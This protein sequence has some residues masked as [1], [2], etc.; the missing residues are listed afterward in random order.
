MKFLC[1]LFPLFALF[2]ASYQE[3]DDQSEL[4]L[5]QPTFEEQQKAKI[6]LPNGLRAYLISDPKADQSGAA[7]AVNVGSWDDPIDRS[8]MAHFVEHMLFYGN[9]TYP[10]DH[11]MFRLTGD[12]NGKLNAFTSFDR[13]VYLFSVNHET[14][15]T[16]LD[17]LAHFVID[18]CFDD[19]KM[20]QELNA[21]DQEYQKNS[22]HDGWRQQFIMKETGNPEHPNAA[23]STGN[24][25]TLSTITAQE[26]EKW[27]NAHYSADK[28]TLVVYSNEPLDTLKEKVAAFFYAVPKK[29]DYKLA[30]YPPLSS[31]HQKGSLIAIEPVKDIKILS[32]VWELPKQFIEDKSKAADLVAYIL[33]RDHEKSL[34]R[35]LKQ[36]G[37]AEDLAVATEKLG[38]KHILFDISIEL[39][40]KGVKHYE[41]VIE[42]S[43]AAIHAIDNVPSTLYDE[44]AKQKTLNY[45][46][47][48]RV[49]AFAYLSNLGMI[50]LDEPLTTFPKE[51]LLPSHFDPEKAKACL[52]ALSP[53]KCQY[54]LLAPSKDTKISYGK[55][56][57][58]YQT[59]YEVTPFQSAQL[60]IWE[61]AHNAELSLPSPNPFVPENLDLVESEKQQEPQKLAESPYGIAYYYQ[62]NEM[63]A[64]FITHCLHIKSPQINFS[65]LSQVSSHIFLYHLQDQL[66]MDLRLAQES[67]MQSKFSLSD[68]AMHITLSGFSDKADLLLEKIITSLHTAPPSQERFNSIKEYLLSAFANQTKEMPFLY[69]NQLAST[70]LNEDKYTPQEMLQSLEKLTYKQYQHFHE[71]FLKKAYIEAFFSGNI[72][73]KLAQSLWLDIHHHL[74]IDPFP[75]KEQMEVSSPSIPD[76][77]SALPFSISMKGNVCSLI[78]DLGPFSHE[79]K[80][81]QSILSKALAEA[82]FN[83]LRTKQQTAYI[84]KAWGSEVHKEL[85]QFFSVQSATHLPSDLLSRFELFLES[86]L[87]NFSKNIPQERFTSIKK[88]LINKLDN[89]GKSLQEKALF[90]DDIAFSHDADFNWIAKQKKAYENLTYEEFVDFSLSV[91]SK[92]NPKRLA[93]LLEGKMDN[94]P[95][96]YRT[97]QLDKF[98]HLQDPNHAWHSSHTAE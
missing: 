35:L 55:K 14:F 65:P 89:F 25:K 78:I 73:K 8:G 69:G 83:E 58:W 44:M 10:E 52:K 87:K 74:R 9:H 60:Y 4:V 36:K 42:T 72:N 32:L 93:F 19:S 12:N 51:I 76:G 30:S 95:F 70:Y 91:L 16:T 97:I 3:I 64:P 40:Q 57:K 20:Q 82:F 23:F 67:N 34:L 59:E 26:M 13:T 37:W 98:V 7:L 80:A 43:F 5:L 56:E 61:D 75:K 33:Q 63:A 50:I 28:M 81:A 41:D 48:N 2:G 29:K 90:Y 49:D 17:H 46:Y 94:E 66:E 92:Q 79:K 24:K 39:T 84:A 22:E 11:A 27:F 86:Y 71:T 47:Q 54:Y 18:P 62:E 88:N 1:T 77:P 31:V 45:Q 21:V 6:I 96:S 53:K 38:D 68:L 15:F 85:L